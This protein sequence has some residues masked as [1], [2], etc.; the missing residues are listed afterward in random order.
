MIQSTSN[1]PGF[2]RT[3]ALSS[4]ISKKTSSSSQADAG[5]NDSLSSS[6]TENL[7]DALARTPEVRS[8]VVE[9]GKTLAAD[10]TYPPQEIIDSLA[11]LLVASRD[12][13]SSS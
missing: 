4:S 10:S 2:Y 1:I 12:L 7:R 3:D 8:D 13:S 11:K 9:R 6:N 5:I